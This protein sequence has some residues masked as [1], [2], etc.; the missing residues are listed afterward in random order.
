MAVWFWAPPSAGFWMGSHSTGCGLTICNASGPQ[1]KAGAQEEASLG[2][3]GEEEGG[4][5]SLGDRLAVLPSALRG[6][7]YRSI[8]PDRGS[9]EQMGKLRPG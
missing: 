8:V 9:I 6:H 2:I 1:N 5:H 4:G 7:Q 3:H